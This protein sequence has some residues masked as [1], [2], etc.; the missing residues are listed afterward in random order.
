MLDSSTP[1]LIA[2]LLLIYYSY[3][4][5][6]WRGVVDLSNPR[7]LMYH[8]VTEQI[9]GAK[10]NGLRV[11]PE[12]FEK[13]IRYLK[14]NGWNSF[15]VSEMIG[16]RD[17]LPK[18]SVAITFDDGFEDNFTKALPI[19][20]KY[21]F[22]ATIYLVNNRFDN[23]WSKN[24]KKKNSNALINEPKLSDDQVKELLNS[25]L[26]EIGSHTLNHKNFADIDV[27]ET[28]LEMADS[29]DAIESKFQIEC[30][31]F[32]YPFGIYKKGDEKIAKEVGF[33]CALTTH[34]GIA[35]FKNDDLYLLPR[36]TIS[37]KDSFFSF[38]LKMR[39]GKR[40]VNK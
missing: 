8:M 33:T 26:I 40:G 10:F 39:T 16:L 6:W 38:W 3:R 1:L 11:T 19:L 15:T 22:K 24:R 21:G 7:I 13:Q 12:Y 27:K 18:K 35:D 5:A 20:Q 25:N 17:D 31:T 34:S 2:L 9:K 14:E 32:A 23:D 4:Y 30:K 28:R 29:K 37:G 36:V